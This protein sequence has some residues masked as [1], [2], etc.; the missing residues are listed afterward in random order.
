MT[1]TMQEGAAP[2]GRRL[3]KYTPENVQKIGDLVAQG[4]S[5]EKI[6]ESLNV[7]L[8]PLQVT[9][10]R[11]GDQL[12]DTEIFQRQRVPLDGRG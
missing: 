11:L 9:C 2:R 12:A 8:G 7:T 10:S 1:M 5:R 4:I 6:A 3:T